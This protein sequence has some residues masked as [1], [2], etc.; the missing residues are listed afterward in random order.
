MC[1]GETIAA[2]KGHIRCFPFDPSNKPALRSNETYD[3]AMEILN[4]V[5]YK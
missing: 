1:L 3:A 4:I 5:H 2:G